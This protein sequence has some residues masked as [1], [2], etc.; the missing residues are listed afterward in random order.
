M[1]LKSKKG[2]PYHQK[3]GTEAHKLSEE[4]PPELWYVT[5]KGN[6]TH[7]VCY[8]QEIIPNRKFKGTFSKPGFNPQNPPS[9]IQNVYPSFSD[10][11]WES[12]KR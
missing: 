3:G 7:M 6:T 4:S 5:H 12:Y 10:K 9:V 1:D 8:L 2:P 11:Y